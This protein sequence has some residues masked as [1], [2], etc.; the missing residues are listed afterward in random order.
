M[1]AIQS[2]KNIMLLIALIGAVLFSWLAGHIMKHYIPELQH[3][4]ESLPNEKIVGF[5]AYSPQIIGGARIRNWGDSAWPACKSDV[6]YTS[7]P[8]KCRSVDGRLIRVG[9]SRQWEYLVVPTLE[10]E[11]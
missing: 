7:L 4:R 6:Y 2:I 3:P 5:P 10:L 1:Q 9:E 11:K 8:A